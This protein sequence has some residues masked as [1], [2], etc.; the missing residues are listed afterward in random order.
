MHGSM[1]AFK[2]R[3]DTTI[4]FGVTRPSASEKSIYNVCDHSSA[5]SFDRIFLFLQVNISNIKA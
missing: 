5:F 4:N 1:N 3:P 2:F